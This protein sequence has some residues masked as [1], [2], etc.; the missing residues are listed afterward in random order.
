MNT[1]NK[2]GKNIRQ[3]RVLKGL[4]QENVADEIGMTHG[5]FGKIERGEID[6]NATILQKISQVLNV[7]VSE[8]FEF[9][10]KVLLLKEPNIKYG[11]VSK[12]DIN[13]LLKAIQKLG[14]EIEQLKK[15]TSKVYAKSSNKPPKAPKKK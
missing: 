14:T 15:T 5:N 10:S 6:V 4:S 2:V 9:K 12:E 7:P 8:L 3:F 1:R 11:H 13:S